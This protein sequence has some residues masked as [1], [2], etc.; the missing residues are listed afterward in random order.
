[1]TNHHHNAQKCTEL[2]AELNDY[3]DGNL[4]AE[5]CRRLEQHMTDCPDCQ[6]VQDTLAQTVALYRG[7]GNVPAELPADVEDRL[8]QRLRITMNCDQ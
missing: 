8:A 5:L 6:V 3:I 2:L 7:L 4:A 1:M